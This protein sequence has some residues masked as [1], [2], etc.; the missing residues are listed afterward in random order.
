MNSHLMSSSQHKGQHLTDPLPIESMVH[1]MSKRVDPF[2]MFSSLINAHLAWISHPAE[3]A[4]AAATIADDMLALQTHLFKRS[5]GLPSED[6]VSPHG[7]DVRFAE[8]V[9]SERATWDIVKELYLSL[10]HR[11]QDMYF[12]TPGLSD[13]DRRKSAFWARV[14]INALAPTN[15]LFTNPVALHKFVESKG[16]SLQSGLKNLVRDMR[17]KNILMVEQDAFT[18]GQ[19]LPVRQEKLCF[20]ANYLN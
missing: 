18:V 13:A 8:T 20:A 6:V 3:F 11:T 17:A 1:D 10:T 9:W 19:I 7:D 2:G 4:R 14:W 16:A 15:F 12:S 5:L